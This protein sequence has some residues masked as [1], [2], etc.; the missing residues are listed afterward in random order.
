MLA[1]LLPLLAQ[2]PF[3][4]VMYLLFRSPQVAGG[5]NQM[6][7][8]ALFGVPL[9]DDAST[10]ASR[11]VEKVLTMLSL[12][13]P[14]PIRSIID[15]TISLGGMMVSGSIMPRR[16]QISRDATNPASTAMRTSR[17]AR[18]RVTPPAPGS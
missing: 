7:T 1:G 2:W 10:K 3:F 6:L 8:H 16:Q 13:S 4:S 9:G 15:E 12:R 18:R 11:M 17:A 5:P 14:E